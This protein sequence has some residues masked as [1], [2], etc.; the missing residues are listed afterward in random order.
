MS[1][2]GSSSN[3][4][5][6]SSSPTGAVTVQSSATAV[7][8][9]TF[10]FQQDLVA[11]LL[12]NPN[13]YKETSGWW[14]PEHFDAFSYLSK[15]LRLWLELRPAG[16][17]DL[18]TMQTH[19]TQ[20]CLGNRYTFRQGETLK[21]HL[22]TDEEEVLKKMEALF[23]HQVSNWSA[24]LSEFRKFISTQSVTDA[25]MAVLGDIESGRATQQSAIAHLTRAFAKTSSVR[26]AGQ[27]FFTQPPNLN[28]EIIKG[29][30]RQGYIGII[31]GHSKS[32]K[33][34]MMLHCA[35]CVAL[36]R[37]WLG[38]D[39]LPPAKALY[40]NLELDEEEFKKRVDI[41][42]AA[43]GT[44]RA[45]LAGKLDFLNLKG[46]PCS[47]ETVAGHL[48]LL[49]DDDNPWEFVVIDDVYKMLS[50]GAEMSESE[51]IENDAGAIG[52]F[53]CQLEELAK[54]LNTAIWLI[55][56]FKKGSAADTANIDAGSGSGV[57]GRAPDVIFSIHP[58]QGEEKT[59]T[60]KN[61]VRY[62]ADVGDFAV[63]LEFPLFHRDHLLDEKNLAGRVGR[64][65]TSNRGD[66]LAVFTDGEALTNQVWCDRATEKMTEKKFRL[67]RDELV[68]EELVE[69]HG[70]GR[71]VTYCITEAGKAELQRRKLVK[72]LSVLSRNGK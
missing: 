20:E 11:H 25:M 4:M 16:H 46:V 1:G 33:S 3:N 2:E 56:H 32:F 53:F 47:L 67:Y 13:V 66:A 8:H 44:T 43:M 63:R 5:N 35:I 9:L 51:N 18:Q 45:D 58:L 14:R 30:I 42:C 21:G 41:V 57:F 28:K 55:H 37:S 50:S 65:S 48:R 61:D 39:A 59:Y 15:I 64:P 31:N 7:N 52:S 70:A 19:F 27:D 49:R 24:Y 26:L 6:K 54:E 34:W 38:F 36:G 17:P 23:Q 71:N 69:Q 12:R 62:W 68:K 40:A 60:I 10:A 72:P 22:T 29:I